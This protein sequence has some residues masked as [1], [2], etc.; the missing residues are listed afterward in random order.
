MLFDGLKA[1]LHLMGI[2]L[3]PQAFD[4]LKVIGFM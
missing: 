4:G 1:D 2:G 3:V